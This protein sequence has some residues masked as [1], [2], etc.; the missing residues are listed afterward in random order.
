[1]RS[2][3]LFAAIACV[4]F[5]A[6]L[7]LNFQAD[8]NLSNADAD[9][10]FRFTYADTVD[11]GDIAQFLIWTSASVDASAANASAKASADGMLGFGVLP[12]GGMAPVLPVSLFAYGSGSGS[13][14]VNIEAIAGKL[15]KGE[16]ALSADFAAGV[17]AVAALGMQE[18]DASN[19]AVGDYIYLRPL[20]TC[21]GKD[22]TG[23]AGNLT[24]F[25]CT[26][27]PVTVKGVIPVAEP[28]KD[29]DVT[30]TYIAS[31]KAGILGYGDTPVSPRSLETVID[32][33]N[34]PLS[35]NENHVRMDL[36]F[37]SVTAGGHVVGKASEVIQREG[38]EDIYIA[39]SSKAIV[40][41]DKVDVTVEITDGEA[42]LG[43]LANA[44]L[45]AALGA[46]FD[47]KVAHVDFPA[48]AKNFVYDPALGAGKTTVYEAA[49]D[50]A[51]T[52]ALSL[53]VLLISV[54][55]YLF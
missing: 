48:G 30:I 17:I 2:V 44:A 3:L 6:D 9:F 36:G 47:T 24:G 21:D 46:S 43:A 12:V 54:L 31:K 35:K 33:K 27:N 55:V 41:D 45:K 38:K 28:V 25:Y 5:A 8:A 16:Q 1:M 14:D 53:L 20:L 26:F 39:A 11:I 50:S 13:L 4:A 42:D 19:K 22:L 23:D 15:F 34:F 52:A 10:S 51:A 18:V 37:L 29:T 32:V 49:G 40:G 7:A